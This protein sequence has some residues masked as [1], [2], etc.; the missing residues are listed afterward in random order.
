MEM[1]VLDNF[2]PIKVLMMELLCTVLYLY[3]RFLMSMSVS[4]GDYLYKSTS[5]D[6]YNCL[7]IYIYMSI[8]VESV[9][10]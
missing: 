8:I 1:S 2:V 9:G 4:L 5:C 7:Y 6:V 10:Q 3:R